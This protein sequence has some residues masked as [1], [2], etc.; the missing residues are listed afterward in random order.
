MFNSII[1]FISDNKCCIE[2]C[3][4]NNY[5]LIVY[6]DYK[7]K[8]SGQLNNLANKLCNLK[9]LER[10]KNYCFKDFK[11]I[12]NIEFDDEVNEFNRLTN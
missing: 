6:S 2:D 7:N 4:K 9:G 10:F 11:F 1:V 8:I 5:L 3:A 12:T